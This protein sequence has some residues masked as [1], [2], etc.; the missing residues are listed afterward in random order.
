MS[1]E[2][3]RAKFV[4]AFFLTAFIFLVIVVTNNYFNEAKLN[5]LNSVYNNIRIDALN[6]EVQYEII[7]ENPCIALDFAPISNELA[8]LG[9][10]LTDME[11]QLGKKNQ[12]VLDL[13]KYY[14]I[15]E[16]RQW[17]FV[18]KASK[19]CNANAT[20]VLFFYSNENDCS[21]C[22]SQGFVLNYIR[23]SQ[24][25]VYVYSFDVNL[26]TSSIKTLKLSYNITMTPSLVIRD[27]TYLGF[28]DADKIV[29]ILRTN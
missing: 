17:L 19:Q 6:A 15:L 11:S 9:D 28:H 1:R 29:E 16:I 27:K 2:L 12:Q 18:K 7:S 3:P 14:S 22:E 5:H 4:A 8:E 24:P 23:K 13:K 10:K 21:D 26:D 20:P 25:N